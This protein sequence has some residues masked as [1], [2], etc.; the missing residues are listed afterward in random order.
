M[1][2]LLR[3]TARY[4]AFAALVALPAAAAVTV[5]FPSPQYTDLGRSRSTEDGAKN[6]LARFV[7]A[8]DAKYLKPGEDLWLEFVDVTLAGHTEWIK[9]QEVR[10]MRGGADWPKFTLR[11]RMT[12]DGKVTQAEESISDMNY[13]WAAGG[14]AHRSDP[15]YYE[16]QLLEHWFRK[17]FAR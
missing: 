15:Y 6:E 2:I 13:Q 10:V 17:R 9:G 16:K 14:A 11:Y 3:V 8:L 12:R 7:H 1:N 4:A 5:S